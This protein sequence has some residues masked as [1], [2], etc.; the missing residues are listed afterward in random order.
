MRTALPS[1]ST[2]SAW[3]SKIS[4]SFQVLLHVA[5]ALSCLPSQ[6]AIWLP[7]SSFLFFFSSVQLWPLKWLFLKDFTFLFKCFLCYNFLKSLPTI[8]NSFQILV[9]SPSPHTACGNRNGCKGVFSFSFQGQHCIC[10]RILLKSP[11]DQQEHSDFLSLRSVFCFSSLAGVNF[12]CED[13]ETSSHSVSIS[14]N[15]NYNRW[16]NLCCKH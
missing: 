10:S 16:F 6:E 4:S 2:P 11:R 5:K 14:S 1:P 7:H 15:R 3:K 12:S 8:L 13:L 9:S